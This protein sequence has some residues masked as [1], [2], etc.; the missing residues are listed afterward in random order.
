MITPCG[1]EPLLILLKK[2]CPGALFLGRQ[3]VDDGVGSAGRRPGK[4]QVSFD[5]T[6]SF[7]NYET[8]LLFRNLN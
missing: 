5:P 2:P 3:S 7:F 8:G 1:A 6:A 4:A